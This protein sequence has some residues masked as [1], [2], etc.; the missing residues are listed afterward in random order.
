MIGP[1]HEAILP[2][3]L[4]DRKHIVYTRPDLIDLIPLCR[5][6]LTNDEARE[7][8]R[9]ASQQYFDQYVHRDQLAQNYLHHIQKRLNSP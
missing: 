1:P 2:E 5:Y 6:S 9:R 7:A 4:E 8:I 3:P